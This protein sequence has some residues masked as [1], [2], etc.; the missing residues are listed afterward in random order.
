M[1]TCSN[2]DK[3]KPDSEKGHVPMAAKLGYFL[4]PFTF[5]FPSEICKSN[6]CKECA[7]KLYVIGFAWFFILVAGLTVALCRWLKL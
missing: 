1:F 2:C 3:E 4:C 7:P 5:I 6:I